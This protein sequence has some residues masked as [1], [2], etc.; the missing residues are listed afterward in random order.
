MNETMV[1]YLW[2]PGLARLGTGKIAGGSILLLLLSMLLFCTA[3]STKKSETGSARHSSFLPELNL[4]RLD[5]VLC[6]SL[7]QSACSEVWCSEQCTESHDELGRK[8]RV[9][10]TKPLQEPILPYAFSCSAQKRQDSLSANPCLEAAGREIVLWFDF[11]IDLLWLCR[12]RVC[13]MNL[14]P[15]LTRA[16]TRACVHSRYRDLISPLQMSC[17]WDLLKVLVFRSLR[18]M[19]LWALYPVVSEKNCN[20]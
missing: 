8:G 16:C 2:S 14:E 9:L 3:C 20:K 7:S 13:S 10:G 19:T 17:F 6:Q 11:P 4:T 12:I 1:L 15:C 5:L 18:A